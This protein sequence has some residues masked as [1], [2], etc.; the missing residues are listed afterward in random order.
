MSGFFSGRI[1]LGD[2][3]NILTVSSSFTSLTSG[4]G[5]DRITTSSLLNGATVNLGG[6]ADTLILGFNGSNA[7]IVSNTETVLGGGGGDTVTYSGGV[8]GYFA[9]LGGGADRII[10][11]NGANRI[12]VAKTRRACWR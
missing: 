1:T 6:G 10:L 3:P 5:A 9:D 4:V 2:N 7:V 11:P 12:S 8:T